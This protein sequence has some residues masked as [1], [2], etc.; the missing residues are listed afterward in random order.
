MKNDINK[1]KNMDLWVLLSRTYHSILQL[2]DAESKQIGFPRKPYILLI[3]KTLGN[4]ATLTEI[5]RYTFRKKNSLSELI[6]RMVDKGLVKKI[7]DPDVKSRIRVSLTK[8][9]LEAYERSTQAGSI[10]K[11]MSGLSEGKQRQLQ[12]C[13]ELLLD[14]TFK[15]L[16]MDRKKILLPSQLAEKST[17]ANRQKVPYD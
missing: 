10:D 11:I 6:N 3:I 14:N 13:L 16:T 17:S 7:R 8:K 4:S 12:S 2:Y 15:E 1:T 9:G 5:S